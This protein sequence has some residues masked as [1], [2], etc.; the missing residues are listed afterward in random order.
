M[1]EKWNIGTKKVRSNHIIAFGELA[2][3]ALKLQRMSKLGSIIPV[4]QK[5]NISIK[6]LINNDIISI[7]I[8]NSRYI[9]ISKIN[10]HNY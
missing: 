5:H 1:I 6:V 3:L 9:T 10:T 7:L 8:S 4:F 2:T